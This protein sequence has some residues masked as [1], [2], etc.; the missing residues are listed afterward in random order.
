LSCRKKRES[1]Q[2]P[3]IPPAQLTALNDFYQSLNGDRWIWQNST[4]YGA[5]WNFTGS[6]NPCIDGWQGVA[7]DSDSNVAGIS[8]IGYH[9]EGTLPPTLSNL[10]KLSTLSLEFNKIYGSIP[11]GY[12][13][14]A[15]LLQLLISFNRLSGS[16]P[17]QLGYLGVETLQLDFNR[18][19]G[20]I[21]SSFVH[22]TAALNWGFAGNLLTGTLPNYL[23][24]MQSLT[25]MDFYDN[26][27]TGTIPDLPPNTAYINFMYNQLDGPLPESIAQLTH[28]QLLGVYQ[29]EL[30]G[31]LPVSY[32]M[33]S[34]LQNF[35]VFGN[36]F[37]GT[38]PDEYG[39]WSQ[40]LW[41]DAHDN[42]LTGSI[43]DSAGNWSNVWF[44]ALDSNR[45]TGTIPASI[46]QIS[47]LTELLLE[48]NRF[49]GSLDNLFEPAVQ[50]RLS[51][52]QLNDNQLTGTIPAAVFN[53]PGLV[54]F[55][56][57]SNCFS[58]TLPDNVCGAT[59][60]HSL[61]ID[62]MSSASNCRSG[63]LPRLTSS[64]AL[65]H[66]SEQTVPACLFGLPNLTALHL[67]GN[68]FTGTLP[69]GLA[70][71]PALVSLSLSHNALTGTIP[72]QFQAQPWFRLD[73]SYNRLSGTLF[74][75]WEVNNSLPQARFTQSYIDALGASR[76]ERLREYNLTLA[77]LNITV[78]VPYVS[79]LLDNNRLSGRIPHALQTKHSVSILGSNVFSCNS[80]QSNLPSHN[81]GVGH[82]QCGSD[83]FNVPYYIW[84]CILTI[85]GTVV[86]LLWFSRDKMKSS[87]DVTQGMRAVGA[88]YSAVER[89]NTDNTL[90][91]TNR[92]FATFRAVARLS[93]QS[94]V[95]I[96]VILLPA[97]VA[98]SRYFGTMT[99]QY[100]WAVSGAY[101]SG[102]A[103][104]ALLFVLLL[105]LVSVVYLSLSSSSASQRADGNGETAAPGSNAESTDNTAPTDGA[106]WSH[107]LRN[108]AVYVVFLSINLF[109]VVGV[110]VAYV[111]VAISRGK[112]LLL[113]AQIAL[114]F[115]KLLWGSVCSPAML[116]FCLRYLSAD[117]D[118]QQTRAAETRFAIVQI[119]VTLFNNIAVPCLV[120][121][122]VSPS[123]FYNVFVAAAKVTSNYTYETCVLIN[124]LTGQCDM[125][126]PV[127]TDTSYDPPFRYTY[128]CS[129]G[130]I[131]YY[132]PAFVALCVVSG[133]L[134]PI[135][136]IAVGVLHHR[137]VLGSVWFHFLDRVTPSAL[138]G[139]TPQSRHLRPPA[140]G[141]TY[142]RTYPLFNGSRILIGLIMLAGL[143]LTFGAMFPPLAASLAVTIVCLTVWARVRVGRLLSACAAA[144][145]THVARLIENECRGLGAAEVMRTAMWMLVTVSCWFYTLFLFDTL[146][147][148]VGFGGAYWVLVVMPLMPLVLYASHISIRSC[149]LRS[150]TLLPPDT[151]LVT[152]SALHA[153]AAQETAE[154]TSS[155]GSSILEIQ[156]YS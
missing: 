17:D 35:K 4:L 146:G 86:L 144:E 13:A 137:A 107:S 92:A 58:G 124:R 123:C 143:L 147:D 85:I 26:K 38:N 153:S 129:S 105:G 56:A 69:S 156:S 118:A 28:L 64:Y 89:L 74:G 142:E 127:I 12:G 57:V 30:T 31:S 84:L 78:P 104:A 71:S 119:F 34:N 140:E 116:R 93:V 53:L 83:S 72:A 98:C 51:V 138:K 75:A 73:L 126:V 22:L 37:T 16:L 8:L 29:N 103:P 132:A 139:V 102:T 90:S 80:R 10:V 97:Y 131:T 2:Q 121:A 100:A 19:T 54:T 117:S 63:L 6:P 48:H 67:S 70:L 82:Y 95:Y 88:W 122:A 109:V 125:L 15:E 59:H 128:Q 81:S 108:L 106:A 7:C 148:A 110:N 149:L 14:F 145:V 101:L 66:S 94:L 18:L 150:A 154:E 151:K 134:T 3:A 77:R 24:G 33:L 27:F 130:L 5:H 133:I 136:Q 99:H 115:F 20:T 49:T 50:A 111:Y 23:S 11:A 42:L 60:L 55:A 9:L 113:F 47:T 36:H 65:Q 152:A 114:S 155:R 52:I 32:G 135:A 40:L 68:G 45:L 46:S 91:R 87:F 25:A 141:G 76:L 96:L 44:I 62:G 79:I 61:I 112:G 43:P 39:K 21:P 41:I 120:V 1:F